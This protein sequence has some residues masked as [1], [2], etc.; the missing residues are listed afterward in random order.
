MTRDPRVNPA[1]GDKLTL[2]GHIATVVPWPNPC[3][4]HFEWR[5]DEWKC[6]LATWQRH[7]KGGE[8]AP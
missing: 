5:G 4:V 8:I 1:P 6:G 2:R 7:V 3:E